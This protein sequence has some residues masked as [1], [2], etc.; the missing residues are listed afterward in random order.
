MDI[1]FVRAYYVQCLF[2]FIPCSLL[3]IPGKRDLNTQEQMC[4]SFE[5]VRLFHFA[6][7]VPNYFDTLKAMQKFDIY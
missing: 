3:N 2:Y 6:N 7:Y 1:V 4:L 5:N